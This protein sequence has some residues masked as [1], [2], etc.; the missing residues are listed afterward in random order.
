MENE[1]KEES[2][3][4]CKELSETF[5]REDIKEF[6]NQK[7]G[8]PDK[9]KIS[10]YK[11][12]IRH[13][14]TGAVRDKGEGKGRCDLLPACSLLRL[15]KHYETGANKYGP[16]NWELGQPLSVLLDSG[17][18]HLLNYLD[19][20]TDED[21]LAAG[22]WNILGAMWMEEKKPEMQDIPSRMKKDSVVLNNEELTIKDG[23]GNV[24]LSIVDDKLYKIVKF[25]LGGSIDDA[26]HML[27]EYTEKGVLAHGVFNGVPLYS[28]N[29]DV[30][31]I[32][33]KITGLTKEDFDLRYGLEEGDENE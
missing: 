32:Y 9:E 21:H 29:I 33:K 22:A 26:I 5:T 28:D 2:F 27:N 16:R 11:E 24:T 23:N 4:I 13:F 19:G 3:P 31:K 12:Q 1:N 7:Y 25:K 18:R 10:Q 17:I 14:N 15:S 8:V 6:V 30:S 20:K